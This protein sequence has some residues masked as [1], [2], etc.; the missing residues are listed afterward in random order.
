MIPA[1][2]DPLGRHWRQPVD[3]AEA[4]IDD[5]HV[6]LT[7]RQ[8]EELPEYSATMPTGAYPGKCWK[9]ALYD[10]PPHRGGKIVGWH[11]GWYGEC[12]DPNFVTNNWREIEVV[13]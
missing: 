13:E 11:L 8:F 4:P 5:T 7:P 6:L 2:T 1:M 12:E 9:R 10:M 3:I